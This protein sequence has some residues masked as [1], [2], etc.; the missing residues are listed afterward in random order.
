[1]MFESGEDNL[2]KVQEI[3]N[4]NVKLKERVAALETRASRETREENDKLR[5]RLAVTKKRN[6]E[7][8]TQKREEL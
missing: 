6:E 2:K 4:E 7:L 1:M 3:I 5:K 8:G